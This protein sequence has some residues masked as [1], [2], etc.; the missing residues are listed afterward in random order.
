MNKTIKTLLK[1]A[2]VLLDK[3]V[4]LTYTDAPAKSLLIVRLDAIGDFIIW[5][6]SAKEYRRL[7][8]EHKIILV[9]NS[10]W[11][12]LAKALPYWDEVWSVELPIFTRNLIYRSK[13]LRQISK[14]G[15]DIAIQPTFSRVYLH[16]DSI[17]RASGAT[18]RIGSVGD[19]SNISALDKAISDCWYTR[20]ISAIPKSL[21]ELERNAEFISNL[22][23]QQFNAQLPKLPTLT[24][25]PEQLKHAKNYFIIFPS[26]S[27]HGRQWFA[28]NFALVLD[29]LHEIYGWQPVL[30]G[31]MAD[32]ELCSEVA[33]ASKSSCLNLAGNTSLLELSEL[34]RGAN[35]LIG[36][37]TSAV[38]FSVAV[39]TPA[40]CVLGGGHYGRFMPYPDYLVGIKPIGVIHDMP[41]FN[42]NWH[43]N[44]PHK[45]TEPVPCIT[46]VDIEHVLNAAHQAIVLTV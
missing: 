37:E 8:P 46:N 19:V 30:C 38:H 5:L 2:L 26:A 16:G 42:C 43:C 20:L 12:E 6:D 18:Q 40:V 13:I 25:L 24:L 39:S 27:W 4:S 29:R 14:A 45:Q 31:S 1:R 11:G 15:F 7:Y 10:V 3:L 32:V 35:L 23:S 41:C 44:Q 22:S 17:I 33:N 34:I 9:A 36:N 21:M 28:A